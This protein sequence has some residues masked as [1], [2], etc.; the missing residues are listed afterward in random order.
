MSRFGVQSYPFISFHTILFCNFCSLKLKK[1]VFIP[2]Q[3]TK[4]HK[5]ECS[6][7]NI[8]RIQNKVSIF[9]A[10]ETLQERTQKYKRNENLEN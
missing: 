5:V 1:Q 8:D 9:A 3:E 7:Y 2:F 10:R 6:L 4:K